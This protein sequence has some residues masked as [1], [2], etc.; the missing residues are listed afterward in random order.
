[1]TL[2]IWSTLTL[3]VAHFLKIFPGVTHGWAVRYDDD[4]A[5]AVKSAEEALADM[6]DWFDK[7]LK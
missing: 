4:D 7:Y 3:Q 1:M 2:P 5:A 6:M